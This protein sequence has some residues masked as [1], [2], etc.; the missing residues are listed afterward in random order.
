[1]ASMNKSNV[2]LLSVLTSSSVTLTFDTGATKACTPNKSEFINFKKTMGKNIGGI[3]NDLAIEG[4]GTVKYLVYASDGT[5]ITLQVEAYYVPSLSSS[6]R[7]ISP[8]DIGTDTG[9]DGLVVFPRRGSKIETATLYIVDPSFDGDFATLSSHT[10]VSLLYNPSNCLPELS[11]QVPNYC[12]LALNACKNVADDANLNLNVHQKELLKWH[13][14]LGHI[15]FKH[16][17]WLIRNN[18]IPVSG[19]AKLIA[20]CDLPKC[21][22]CEFGK[23]HRRPTKTSMSKPVAAKEGEL[24]KNDLFPGQRIST[25]HYQ[26]ST[27]GRLY[28]SRGSTPVE[29]MYCGGCIFVDHAS[30]YIETCHQV[31]LSAADTVKSKIRF[32]RKASQEGVIIQSYHSDNGIFNSTDFMEHLNTRNQTIRFSGAGAAHQNGIAERAIKT[33]VNMARTML[34]H[35]DLHSPGGTISMDL[36]PMAMDH[37]VWLY[38][39]IPRQENGIAPIEIWSRTTI[40]PYDSIFRNCHTWGCPTFVLEPKLQKSGVKIP[41]W[42]PRSRKGL[43]MGFSKMHSSLVSLILNQSTGSISPQFHVVFDD[44]F[45]TV[46]ASESET[47]REWSKLISMPSARFQIAVEESAE[48]ELADEWLTPTELESRMQQQRA[49]VVSNR[50]RESVST[51][52]QGEYQLQS[53]QQQQHQVGQMYQRQQPLRIAGDHQGQEV[54]VLTNSLRDASTQEPIIPSDDQDLN[55]GQLVQEEEQHEGQQPELRRSSRSKKAPKL[56]N[57]GNFGAAK[58]WISDQVAMLATSFEENSFTLADWSEMLCTLSDVDSDYCMKY[59]KGYDSV[60]VGYLAKHKSDPDTPTYIEAMSGEHAMGYFNDMK[61]EITN[62]VKRNTWTT[63]LRSEIGTKYPKAP[64]IPSTW[65]LRCKRRPDGSFLKNR[66][67]F[68]VRGDVQK[69]KAETPLN[70]YAPV[71]MWSTIRLMLIMS[72]LLNLT[73]LSVD[74]S[75]AFAQADIP[76]SQTVYIE[77]PQ[78]F[79]SENGDDIVLKLNKSLYGQAESPRL[80]YEK[81]KKGL[82]DRGFVMSKVDPCLFLSKDIVCICYVDDCLF[83]AHKQEKLD[84]LLKSF[85]EDGDEYNWELKVEGSV[86]EYLGIEIHKTSEGGYQFLQKGLITKILEATKMVD[87]N[88]KSTP[89]KQDAPLGSDLNGELAKREWNYASVIGMMLYLAANSRPDISFAVH[90]CARFTHNTKASHEE[91][92]LRICRYLKG[93]INDGMIFKPCKDSTLDCYV[94]ADFAGLWGHEDPLDPIC[95]RSRT[96]FVITMA[97]CP[98]VWVS[99]LQTEIALSTL[100]AEYVALSQ[101]LREFLPLKDLVKEILANYRFDTSKISYTTKSKV[102]EDN[103]GAIVVATSPRMTPTSKF[104]AVKY[105]WFREHVGKAFDIVKISGNEQIADMFT[106]GLQGE[107]FSYIRKLMCG[108]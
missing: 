88:A 100:H 38:N 97:N 29:D 55:L 75:N 36:W 42:Q 20:S 18:R 57:P 28:S 15:G 4:E 65:A 39:R 6:T 67:R 94:D 31:S 32:E 71:A 93:T 106:K 7:L 83:F 50:R 12:N 105:H 11:A 69:R 27:P 47:P 9:K 74:F 68:C 86:S 22:A 17:Q 54:E 63:I 10:N 23:A 95:V 48:V 98:L 21:A 49:Q 104:I 45:S 14:K 46:H 62:L 53:N 51:T 87:C 1:M 5:P 37:A 102:F 101:S 43:N 80:W 60:N 85:K 56:Y 30:G 96:G 26:S 70:T 89:T 19:N 90:Q 40:H 24:R 91:A 52:S 107:R 72:C 108:W 33:M 73:T 64:V 76:E 82:E 84:E 103:Q 61:N 99:K 34:I 79:T 2:S 77:P 44:L 8:Q 92:V 78:G 13:Y 59:P 41:K 25:D 81:L 66:S 35:A 58:D 3:A 16:L